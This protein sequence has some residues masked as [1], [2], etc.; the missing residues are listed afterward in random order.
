MFFFANLHV[1]IHH[2]HHWGYHHYHNQQLISAWVINLTLVIII[3]TEAFRSDKYWWKR[4]VCTNSLTKAIRAFGHCS[5]WVKYWLK[6]RLF[7]KWLVPEVSFQK[8]LVSAVWVATDEGHVYFLVL[9]EEHFLS[10]CE[11]RSAVN[12]WL[13]KLVPLLQLQK[14]AW[15]MVKSFLLDR[16]LSSW[17]NDACTQNCGIVVRTVDLR[18]GRD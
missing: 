10:N 17:L 11:I 3:T 1:L 16:M 5:S 12:D 13:E 14:V 8:N 15:R 6:T 9:Q 7:R 2:F 18:R 4:Y